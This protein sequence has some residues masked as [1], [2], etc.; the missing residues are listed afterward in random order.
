MCVHIRYLFSRNQSVSVSGSTDLL[1]ADHLGMISR[2]CTH[3]Y[4]FV[5]QSDNRVEVHI[6]CSRGHAQIVAVAF[7]IDG[8]IDSRLTFSLLKLHITN[9][10]TVSDAYESSF[11]FLNSFHINLAC[12]HCLISI[13]LNSILLFVAS[14]VCTQLVFVW[15]SAFFQLGWCFCAECC[16]CITFMSLL[17]LTER[18]WLVSSCENSCC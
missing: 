9:S 8:Q 12:S 7:L 10:S 17:V 6:G 14:L 4:C 2:I 11:C 1:R 18:P 5:E 16:D 15:I 3:E 13:V